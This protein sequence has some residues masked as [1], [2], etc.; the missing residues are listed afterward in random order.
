MAAYSYVYN[1]DEPNLFL[2]I[3]WYLQFTVRTLTHT[4]LEI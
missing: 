3:I 2:S 1:N 4:Y